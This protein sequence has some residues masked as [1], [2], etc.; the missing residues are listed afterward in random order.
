MLTGSCPLLG[1]AV[2]AAANT[3]GASECANMN[4]TT[5]GSTSSPV[6]VTFQ[7]VVSDPGAT[8]CVK[9]IALNFKSM[10]GMHDG[11]D[12]EILYVMAAGAPA[13]IRGAGGDFNGVRTR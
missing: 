13:R 9:V 8:Y 4:Y 10:Q 5:V 12:S 1:Y 3:V 11:G 7:F 2:K 6:D